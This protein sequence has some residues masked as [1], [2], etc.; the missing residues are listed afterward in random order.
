LLDILSLMFKAKSSS[1][2]VMLISV[3]KRCQ[4]LPNNLTQWTSN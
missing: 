1:A 3:V 4:I 2:F